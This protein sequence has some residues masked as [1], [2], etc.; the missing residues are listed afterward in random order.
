MD[1]A[2]A[3]VGA[4]HVVAYEVEKVAAVLGEQPAFEA[5]CIVDRLAGTGHTVDTAGKDYIRGTAG[6]IAGTAAGTTA[7]QE[8]EQQ[9]EDR[10]LLQ[11][12]FGPEQKQQE[13]LLGQQ[14][15]LLLLLLKQKQMQM[16][17]EQ[18]PRHL[19]LQQLE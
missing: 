6:S 12:G 5:A 14:Q 17:Q 1:W 4:G 11:T 18:S 9:L 8:P 3:E 19:L 15:E 2:A 16:M 13:L 10:Q 7:Q